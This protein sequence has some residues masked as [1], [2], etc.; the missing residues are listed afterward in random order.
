MNAVRGCFPI[1]FCTAACLNE[2]ESG[3]CGRYDGL[4]KYVRSKVYLILPNKPGKILPNKPAR[5]K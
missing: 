3:Y 1:Q 4:G 2:V 5:N